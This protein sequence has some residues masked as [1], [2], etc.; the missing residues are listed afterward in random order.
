MRVVAEDDGGGVEHARHDGFSDALPHHH[1]APPFGP[2]A[3]DPR[4]GSVDRHRGRC[5]ADAIGIHTRRTKSTPASPTRAR[6][7]TGAA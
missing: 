3:I 5:R 1:T 2:R 6:R 4:P 7:R